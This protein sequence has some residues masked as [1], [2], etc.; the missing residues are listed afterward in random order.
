MG[1]T[2][3]QKMPMLQRLDVLSSFLYESLENADL[4]RHC[5]YENPAAYFR[6][7]RLVIVD[8]TD[9]YIDLPSANSIFQVILSMFCEV[10]LS[11]GKLVVFDEAHKY[12]EGGSSSLCKDMVR[13]VRMMRHYGIRVVV[14]T[15]N[16]EVL[17]Q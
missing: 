7:G 13:L 8:L 14:S 3:Q 17:H 9:H 1:L 11:C 4:R 10:S 5:K 15:Q 12:L 2:T 6:P 16:P